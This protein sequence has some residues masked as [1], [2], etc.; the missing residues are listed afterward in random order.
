MLFGTNVPELDV[1]TVKIPSWAINSQRTAELISQFEPDMMIVSGA[2]VLKPRIFA[3][4]SIG[5]VNVHLGIAP[6]YR[7]TN[8]IFWPL[9]NRDYEH[10]GL[11]LHYVDEGLDSGPIIAQAFPQTDPSDTETTLLAK[12]AYLASELLLE[13]V[14]APRRPAKMM[15]SDISVG[16]QYYS[17][18]RTLRSEFG[19]LLRR[20]LLREKL[21]QQNERRVWTA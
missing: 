3:I 13:F 11:T 9:Y 21:P 1:P 19:Y 4:P 7:G 6:E 2:P 20:Y 12:C 18:E 10:I 5:T 8:N 17:R 15:A 14:Q 16:R